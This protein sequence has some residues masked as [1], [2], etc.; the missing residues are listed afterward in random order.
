MDKSLSIALFWSH[1]SPGNM[2]PE[3][4]GQDNGR[5]ESWLLFSEMARASS[6]SAKIKSLR[7]D[8]FYWYLLLLPVQF[9]NEAS[10][11][12]WKTPGCVEV[13]NSLCS[14]LLVRAQE[15]SWPQAH[16]HPSCAHAQSSSLGRRGWRVGTP[17][18]RPLHLLQHA[19]GYLHGTLS[20]DTHS[21]PAS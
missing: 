10:Q 1:C 7:K 19:A 4:N 12:K 20:C 11:I 14:T 18:C 16:L 9:W 15:L 6:H 17:I 21:N 5:L 2:G 8:E 13:A 3:I